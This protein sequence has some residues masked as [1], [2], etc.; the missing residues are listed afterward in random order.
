LQC[1]EYTKKESRDISP[2]EFFTE[3]IAEISISLEEL[4]VLGE[5]LQ[6]QEDIVQ[7]IIGT[8]PKSINTNIDIAP[9]LLI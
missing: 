1:A 3:A 8:F 7:L 2:T 4:Q 9:N 5:E 6:E